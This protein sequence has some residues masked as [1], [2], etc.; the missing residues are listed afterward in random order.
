M[1]ACAVDDR[2]AFGLDAGDTLDLG[3]TLCTEVRTTK[4]AIVIDCASTAR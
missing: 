1:K 4:K 2:M 3:T